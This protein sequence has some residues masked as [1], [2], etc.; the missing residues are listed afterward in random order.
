MLCSVYERCSVAA[1]ASYST[2]L[3]IPCLSRDQLR[4]GAAL[5]LIQMFQ[6]SEHGNVR[7]CVEEREYLKVVELIFD[8]D[9]FCVGCFCK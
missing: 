6:D 9:E 8:V 3:T 2:L 4:Q 1:A 5:S 7:Y